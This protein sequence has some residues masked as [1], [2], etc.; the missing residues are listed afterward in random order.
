MPCPRR[1]WADVSLNEAA[2]TNQG[3]H[4]KIQMLNDQL[5]KFN[6]LVAAFDAKLTSGQFREMKFEEQFARRKIV[7]REAGG[8]SWQWTDV[9]RGRERERWPRS[10][11]CAPPDP[12]SATSRPLDQPES[13]SLP[14]HADFP[15]PPST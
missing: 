7:P 14:R 11:G 5:A 13:L 10:S 15:L 8:R 12:A 6:S 9:R 1:G 2:F 3:A 4:E